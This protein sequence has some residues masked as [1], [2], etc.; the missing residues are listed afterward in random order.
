[1]NENGVPTIGVRSLTTLVSSRSGVGGDVTLDVLLAGLGSGSPAAMIR[2][3]LTIGLQ[4]ARAPRSSGSRGVGR[5]GT[6]QPDPEAGI[7]RP[8]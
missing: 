6:D 1:M 5:H 7:D 2:A 3:V 8:L 4:P